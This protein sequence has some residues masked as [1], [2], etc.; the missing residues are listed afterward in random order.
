[1]VIPQVANFISIYSPRKAIQLTFFSSI[2]NCISSI[3]DS[4]SWQ[5]T[6]NIPKFNTRVSGLSWL[7]IFLS[8]LFWLVILVSDLLVFQLAK[9]ETSWIEYPNA[10]FDFKFNV[11]SSRISPTFNVSAPLALI[12]T[13]ESIRAFK[14]N[15]YIPTEYYEYVNFQPLRVVT[16][17][18]NDADETYEIIY[19]VSNVTVHSKVLGDFSCHCG[20]QIE[21]NQVN[22]GLL[23]LF[24]TA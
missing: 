7:T 2:S 9:R 3:L 14:N 19:D 23:L 24:L 16:V 15:T 18:G 8:L 1:M 13:S 12:D 5:H 4:R 6:R 22:N 10:H 20:Q 17:N 11:S 21:K